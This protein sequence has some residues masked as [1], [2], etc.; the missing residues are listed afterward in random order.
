MESIN[1]ENIPP[2]DT[3]KIII[4]ATSQKNGA[5]EEQLLKIHRWA[6]DVYTQNRVLNEILSGDI[7]VKYDDKIDDIIFLKSTPIQKKAIQQSYIALDIALLDEDFTKK[8]NGE[9]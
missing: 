6:A 7:M 8:L 3:C 2:R 5:T 1:L 9:E 4:N